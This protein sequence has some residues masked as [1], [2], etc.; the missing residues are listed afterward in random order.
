VKVLADTHVILWWRGDPA[1]LSSVALRMLERADPVLLSPISVWEMSTLLRLGRI[2]LD[3]DLVSWVTD[4]VG[5]GLALAEL[6]PR[7]ASHAG[8]WS[9]DE[10]P[11]DP[12]D[13]LIY[14][15]ARELRVP[16]I[17][18]DERLHSIASRR[19]DVRVIW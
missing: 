18:K 15:T 3:R 17:S 13:R 16:L 7:A 2:R 12:A 8:S 19:G 4:L 11:A 9:V 14:A 6:T 5:E 10:F 1:R